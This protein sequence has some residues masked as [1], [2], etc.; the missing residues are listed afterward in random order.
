MSLRAEARGKPGPFGVPRANPASAPP[1]LQERTM[2][3]HKQEGASGV[4]GT[5]KEHS[6]GR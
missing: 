2:E 5:F 6:D 1:T 4:L 3:E